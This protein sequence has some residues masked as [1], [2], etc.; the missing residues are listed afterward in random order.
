MMGVIKPVNIDIKHQHVVDFDVRQ[1]LPHVIFVKNQATM[2]CSSAPT[3][4]IA[5]I[6]PKFETGLRLL[7][8]GLS[9]NAA[10]ATL[11]A[12][13]KIARI[14]RSVDETGSALSNR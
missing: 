4:M 7:N 2:P 9:E 8:V 13:G 3:A 5:T 11:T 6:V 10:L 1:R 14:A 12:G